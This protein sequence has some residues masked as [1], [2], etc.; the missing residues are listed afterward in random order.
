MELNCKSKIFDDLFEI[1]GQG[2]IRNMKKLF[3]KINNFES[4]VLDEMCFWHKPY[5]KLGFID[6][7]NFKKEIVEE[8][9]IDNV[10]N[11]DS[12]YNV[13]DDIWDYIDKVKSTNLKANNEYIKATKRLAEIKEKYPKVMD[14]YDNNKITEF[15][16]EEMKAILEIKELYDTR[17]MLDS[18]EMFKIGLRQ[19]KSL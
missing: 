19:G 6:G 11:E 4:D 7:M 15:T 16:Q 1:R 17:N 10:D 3:E 8:K 5:Y 14:F 2:L 9:V 13:V 18:E 12:I